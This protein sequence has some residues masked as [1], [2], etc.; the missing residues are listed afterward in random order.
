MI[1][2]FC[3][4]NFKWLLKAVCSVLIVYWMI[5][6]SQISQIKD[7]PLK[8]SDGIKSISA[9]EERSYVQ[10]LLILGSNTTFTIDSIKNSY[11][12]Y[13]LSFASGRL[14]KS[15]RYK[16]YDNIVIGDHFKVLSKEYDVTLATF[17]SMDKLYWIL[18]VVR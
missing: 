11:G 9:T 3:S 4:R 12:P 16:I 8:Y 18:D 1:T 14:D 7:F 17:A 10:N 15:G 13:S 2:K 5:S 6:V